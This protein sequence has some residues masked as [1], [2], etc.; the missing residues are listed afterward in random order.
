MSSVSTVNIFVYTE[1][2]GRRTYTMEE[3]KNADMQLNSIYTL[4]KIEEIVKNKLP[5]TPQ[6]YA[7]LRQIT[8][9]KAF[10]PLPEIAKN[11]Y[12]DFIDHHSLDLRYR[13]KDWP[14]VRRLINIF[15]PSLSFPQEII[16]HIV[17]N[18]RFQDLVSYSEVTPKA[19]RESQVVFE[20]LAISNGY[21]LCTQSFPFSI[22]H[23]NY[24]TTLSFLKEHVYDSHKNSSVN[25]RTV[26]IQCGKSDTLKY[27]FKNE[28]AFAF[29]SSLDLTENESFFDKICDYKSCTL[30][31]RAVFCSLVHIR[32]TPLTCRQTFLLKRFEKNIKKELTAENAKQLTQK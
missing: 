1:D 10:A 28:N 11:A 22:S 9:G 20:E 21:A 32:Y 27:I 8:E 7:S 18:L 25:I 23:I 12:D 3:V 31:E 6:T 5:Y 15:S 13:F 17:Q 30:Q 26:M 2:S 4:D 29:Q 19:S 14:Q 16:K 24:L